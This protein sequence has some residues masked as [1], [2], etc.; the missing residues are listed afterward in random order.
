MPT[1]EI[2]FALA[3]APP[4]AEVAVRVRQL[5]H[6]FY[7]DKGQAKDHVLKDL[8]LEFARGEVV[9]L[10][11][12]SGCGKTTLLTLIGGLRSLQDESRITVFGRELGGMAS[13]DLQQIRY[14]IGFIFQRHN[15]LTSLTAYQ[16]VKM[17]MDLRGASAAD[18]DARIRELMELLLLNDAEKDRTHFLPK[19]LSGGQCQRVAIARALANRPDLVLADEPTAALDEKSSQIVFEELKRLAHDRGAT[20]VIVTH[21]D[22]I[23]EGAD[24]IVS[25]RRGKVASNLS[26]AEA[27]EILK[28]LNESGFFGPQTLM[29]LADVIGRMS[30]ADYAGG[31][32]ILRQGDIGDRMYLIRQGTVDVLRDVNDGR[33]P[34]LVNTLRTG[35][36]FGEQAL[37]TANPRNATI[38]ARGLVQTY[39]LNKDE[40][41]QA[42]AENPTFREQLSMVAAQRN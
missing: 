5:N 3:T 25:L 14:G 42:K 32:T 28:F 37:L 13:D 4:G 6:Y 39:T 18:A 19:K 29:T 8:N 15:L 27:K 24:R 26:V 33:G 40:F 20:I 41:E 34:Q 23:L 38:V 12:P 10:T 1:T 16:N 21:D 31:E 7:K 17:A 35:T 30:R 36:V 11:G 9:I 2:P 22:R